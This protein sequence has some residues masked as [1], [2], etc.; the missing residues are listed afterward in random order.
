MNVRDASI[1][2]EAELKFRKELAL[3][4]EP[5]QPPIKNTLVELQKIRHQGNRAVICAIVRVTVG[6]F[7]KRYQNDF[8]KCLW[9]FF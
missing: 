2:S 4:Q 6:V 3:L 5:E 9:D 1:T 8:L 7:K